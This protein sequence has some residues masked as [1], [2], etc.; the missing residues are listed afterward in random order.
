MT[1]FDINYYKY[2][3]YKQ[4]YL[5]LV[6]GT[7]EEMEKNPFFILEKNSDGKW[8][9]YLSRFTGPSRNRVD[10]F[11]KLVGSSSI[12]MRAKIVKKGDEGRWM[13]QD[14][15]KDS[16]GNYNVS[17]GGWYFADDTTTKK[18]NEPTSQKKL[19]SGVNNYYYNMTKG[20]TD[21]LSPTDSKR[22]MKIKV[23]D[24]TTENTK[25]FLNKVLNDE[26]IKKD[27]ETLKE[28][29]EQMK[30]KPL[31]GHALTRYNELIGKYPNEP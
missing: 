12:L 8:S 28:F 13:V 14:T 25:A 16:S 9:D 20:L 24:D 11:N 1:E 30:K 7:E 3:K 21:L 19:A 31:E 4:K 17:K 15:E 29:K 18:L 5:D 2:L 27:K 26:Q 22:Y 23:L 6:G 10:N